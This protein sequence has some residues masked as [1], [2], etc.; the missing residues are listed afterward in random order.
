MTEISW[1]DFEKVEMRVGTVVAVE[2]FPKARKPALKLKIDLGEMGIYKS[3][4]QIT[5]LYSPAELLGKQVV[6]VI[7]FP[8][9]QIA[10]FR[11][12]C[13]VLGVVGQKN[14][15]VL[16]QPDRNVVNGSRVL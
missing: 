3:S 6:A 2:H 13:L 14:G 1:H 7:N 8:P 4:A 15:V 11:S 16:L 10:D 5:Q 9:K 12:E